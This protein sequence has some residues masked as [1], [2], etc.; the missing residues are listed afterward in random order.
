MDRMLTTTNVTED[1]S[2]KESWGRGGKEL[3]WAPLLANKKPVLASR[4]PQRARVPETSVTFTL[5][6]GSRG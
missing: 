1:L 2:S 4:R 5:Q 3:G 6:Q